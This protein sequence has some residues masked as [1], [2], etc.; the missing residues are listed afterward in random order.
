MTWMLPLLLGGL[1]PQTTFLVIF[2]GTF[3]SQDSSLG[4]MLN[5]AMYARDEF[6]DAERISPFSSQRE[7]IALACQ[8]CRPTFWKQKYVRIE[9]V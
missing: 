1:Y 7:T 3:S 5:L 6:L 8:K 4:Y 9:E 2:D